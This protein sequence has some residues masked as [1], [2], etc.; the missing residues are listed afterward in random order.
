[1]GLD[2][3]YCFHLSLLKFQ[4]ELGKLL[5]FLIEVGWVQPSFHLLTD[6]RPL[7]VDDAVVGAIAGVA[8]HHHVL[9]ECA[10]VLETI[11]KSSCLTRLI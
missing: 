5:A 9:S 4:V 11:A 2:Q 1:M 3:Q 8:F 6:L 7:L 10:F